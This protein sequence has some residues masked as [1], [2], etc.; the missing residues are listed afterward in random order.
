MQDVVGR[1]FEL[2][3]LTEFLGG[4]GPRAAGAH[5][6]AGHRQDHAVGGGDR[7]R[8]RARACACSS[9]RPSG[10]EAQLSF[11]ALIDLFDGVDARR[12]CRRRSA[13]RSRS[14]CCAPTPTG[15]P[16]E[17]HA[18]ALGAAQRAARAGRRG[19]LLVAIDDVQWL[20][21]AV[22][23]RAGVR[24]PPARGRAGRASCS[25]GGPGRRV[26][27]RAGARAPRAASA[28][29]S[30]A[31][32][33]ARCAGLLAERLGLQPPAA[34]A[35]AHRRRR[36]SAT[37]CS[38]SSWGARCSSA[39]LPR[40]GEDI[41]VPDASRT[42][43]G[44]A[45][46]RAARAA[47]AGLLLAVA[48]SGDLRTGRAG[49]G[50]RPRRGRRRARRGLLLVD[51]DRVRASHPLLAAAARSARAPA[52]AARA[53][54]RARRRGRR[55][56]A[57]RAAPRARRPTGPTRSSRRP[58]AAAA[59]RAVRARR[60]EQAVRARRAR[61]AADAAR[62]RP[63][64]PSALL[65]LG[66]YLERAGELQRRHRA[67]DARSSTRCRRAAAR[68]RALAAAAPRAATSRR[69]ADVRAATSS[70]RWPR[71]GDDPAL[72]ADVLASEALACAPPSGVDA[73]RARPRRWALEAL[74]DRARRADGRARSRCAR[75]AGRAACAAGRSTTCCERFT[76]RCPTAPSYLADSPE[77]GGRPAARLARRASTPARGAHRALLALADERG[78]A[79]SYALQRLHLC[80]LE[81]RAGEWDAAE[82]R[83]DE[84][85]ES[86]RRRRCCPADVPSA[87]A[88][89]WPPGA[90]TGAEAE[91]VGGDGARARR[92]ARGYGWRSLE[93]APARAASPRCSRATRRGPPRACARSGSTPSARGSRSPGAF[94]VAPDLVEA[95]ADARRARRG[96]ARSPT[97]L[98]RARRAR[99]TTRGRARPRS[100]APRRAPARRAAYDEAAAAA[101]A[102]AAAAYDAARPALRRGAVAAR[103]GRAQRRHK[104]W[105]AARDV[106]RGGRRGVRRRSARPG[107]AE[108]ARAELARVGARRPR[109]AR[110]A[111]PDRAARRRAGR[112]RARQQGDRAGA[113]RRPCTRSRSHLS[114]AYA[115]LGVRSR[116]QLAG[117]L[118]A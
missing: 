108:L 44:R 66:G 77:R 2:L 63:S 49:G 35:A 95:L 20:D 48:L 57:A 94:P 67:A 36:R 114:R 116:A 71:R 102:E 62:T 13:R 1:D 76:A 28:S 69:F 88:R 6:R 16:P 21:A 107:W 60:R 70:A 55:R 40:V 32:A 81:L 65:A 9:A 106:A 104:Q 110:R 73:D 111:H 31:R 8:A 98:Q 84:W 29:T 10:A 92:E 100:A 37:R 64:A 113:V 43:S 15:A 38:R 50:R 54:P 47:C 7:R 112:R 12:R 46:A 34:A 30:A 117:R 4:A 93:C 97:R 51:G 115:K 96:A 74:R 58:S 72:R 87:A 103:L 24:R 45:S 18:I 26:R 75:S 86:A 41:P 17:P 59:A 53:A 56:R 5:G 11:A 68:V 42:C 27:A 61:A 39:G 22:R 83:L 82:R 90:A 78:E 85:A 101:L 105:G 23:R 19:P 79:V 109:P 91:R 25:R 118:R 14:R 99:R 33:S 89:C 80:E 3:A 52:R